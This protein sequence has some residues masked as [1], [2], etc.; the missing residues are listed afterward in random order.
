MLR[1]SK[2]A[3]VSMSIAIYSAP[4]FAHPGHGIDNTVVQGFLH[5]VSGVDHALAML[6]VGFLAFRL[7]GR[8]LWAIP[9]A[10]IIMM[11]AGGVLGA[12]GIEIPTIEQVIATSVLVLGV[13]MA[14][15]ARLS[16]PFV[17]PVTA[18][19]A[20]F[21]G[22]ALGTEGAVGSALPLSY[23][24]GFLLATA[25]LLGA[26]IVLGHGVSVLQKRDLLQ[27]IAGAAVGLTGFLMLV[28]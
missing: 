21:H 1:I 16:L 5:P 20:M 17:I 14:L 7:G 6:S 23:F 9:A 3:L 22:V 19:F 15:A 27:R 10:F 26:G 11:A 12:T 25:V 28:G 18:L 8:A 2:I 4:A 24:S 13:L